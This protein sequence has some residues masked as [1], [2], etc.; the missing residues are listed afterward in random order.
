M[1]KHKDS[2]LGNPLYKS[3]HTKNSKKSKYSAR[4][5]AKEPMADLSQLQSKYQHFKSSI[6]S[7]KK[8]E[9]T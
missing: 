7:E 8:H 2:I 5:S 4:K 6:P 3:H 9:V 1:E